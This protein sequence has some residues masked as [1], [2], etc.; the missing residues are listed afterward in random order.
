MALVIQQ[1]LLFWLC[2]FLANQSFKHNNL[3]TVLKNIQSDIKA[4]LKAIKMEKE[5]KAEEV[6]SD[7]TSNS[8]PKV[9]FSVASDCPGGATYGQK[10]NGS[11]PT[12][13]M[14]AIQLQAPS[15]HL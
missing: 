3:I 13:A 14:P 9:A 12:L 4:E 6:M 10:L 8:G 5:E 15:L 2:G 1:V 7:Q 11:I